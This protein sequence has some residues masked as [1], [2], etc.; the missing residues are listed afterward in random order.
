[1][2]IPVE[3]PAQGSQLTKVFDSFQLF[4]VK[5]YTAIVRLGSGIQ[6]SNLV[7]SR[8]II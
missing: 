1:M 6:R 8:N 2:Q 4:L 7:L 3:A 5:T